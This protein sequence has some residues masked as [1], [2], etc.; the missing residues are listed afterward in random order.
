M[1]VLIAGVSASGKN[2][3][4]QNL[5]ER[6]ED[7]KMLE[8][9]SATTRPPRD[10]DKKFKNYV[11]LTDEQF[12]EKIEQDY[13]IE[14]ELV[15]GNYY[16]TIKSAFEKAL[17][18]KDIIY[19][20]DIDVKGC[21]SLKKYFNGYDILT[22][23]LDAPDNVLKQRLLERGDSGEQIKL[24]MSRNEFERTF[25]Q[26]YNLIIEN[27]NLVKTIETILNTIDERIKKTKKKSN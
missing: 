24:R 20:K 13:F 18:Q 19:L 25:K 14:Y 3:V 22:I 26:D 12:K 21:Q 11:Y 9:C 6:R 17:K 10:T 1:L 8:F 2:T 5:I 15:H 7:I 16:G 4:I 27:L 23:F